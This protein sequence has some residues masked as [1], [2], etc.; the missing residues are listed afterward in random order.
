MF[1][2]S[3]SEENKYWVATKNNLEINK[4]NRLNIL[5]SVWIPKK[6]R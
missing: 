6:I 4:L 3:V 5:E 1:L 2:S